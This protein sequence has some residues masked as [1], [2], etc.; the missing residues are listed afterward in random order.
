[1]TAR[2]V[3]LIDVLAMLIASIPILY[4]VDNA[5]VQV[6]AWL[7]LIFGFSLFVGLVTAGMMAI[8]Q[9][10]PRPVKPP[11]MPPWETLP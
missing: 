4:R 9:S 3:L 2:R 8:G 7:V 11:D 10:R 5:V 6:T 1:V